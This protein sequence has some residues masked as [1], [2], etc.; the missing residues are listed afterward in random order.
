MT[1]ELLLGG[2]HRGHGGRRSWLPLAIGALCLVVLEVSPTACA[3]GTPTVTSFT[4]ANG[5]TGVA[6]DSALVFA[7]DQPMDTDVSFVPTVP[8]FVVGNM[9]FTPSGSVAAV[10]FQWSDDGRTLT[11]QPATEMP[12][13]T[14]ITWKLNPAGAMIPITSSGGTALATVSG[15]FTTGAGGGG[16]GTAPK[17]VSSSPADGAIDVSV[18]TTVVFVFDQAMQKN[19]ALGGF[20]PTVIGAIAWGGTGLTAT[21]FTYAWSTDGKTLTCTYAGELPGNTE[22]TWALNPGTVIQ[23]Q[24]EAGEVLPSGTYSGSFMTG[25]GSGGEDCNPS[26]VP[27]TWG[28]Y[29]LSK[30]STYVQTSAADPVPETQSPFVFAVFV[31]GPQGGPAPT[32]GSVTL[33]DNTTQPLQALLSYLMFNDTPATQT[34]L[35]TLYPAG[36]YTLR[37]TQTGTAERVISMALPAAGLPVP[38]IANFAAAQA[39][40]ATQDFTLSWNPFTGA[41]ASDYISLTITDEQGN[42]LFQAPNPCVPR[43]LAVTATSIVIPA[44]TL[45][46]NKLYSGSLAFGHLAYSST[47]AVPDMSGFAGVMH[48]TRFT[49]NTGAPSTVGD[50]ARFTGF[51]LL[52]NGNPEMDLTGTATHAYTIQRTGSLTDPNWTSAGTV[53]MDGAGTAVFEDTGAV[54]IFPLFYRAVAN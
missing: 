11:C 2:T 50:P 37:F 31:S 24:N 46:T 43:D 41:G 40:N 18:T 51:R 21:K 10:D 9:E 49:V 42:V 8:P 23:L 7:F 52:P 30:A 15:S 34:A 13:N 29:T 5:A 6:V 20:P 33:P 32:A 12:A 39:V 36:N 25:Q 47:N 14:T 54:K 44:N 45:N 3:Q 19:P 26:G 38:K 35:D 16:G 27:S 22:I 17:L 48:S 1:R 53:T 4:P 28:A